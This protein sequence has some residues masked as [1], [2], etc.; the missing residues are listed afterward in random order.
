[1]PDRHR[2]L[3]EAVWSDRADTGADLLDIEGRVIAIEA[4]RW[5]QCDDGTDCPSDI[6][7]SDDT[8]LL[9][10]ITTVLLQ[11]PVESGGWNSQQSARWLRLRLTLDDE[12][13]VELMC[14]L[15]SGRAQSGSGF[16]STK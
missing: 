10:E 13:T 5:A 8:G 16:R 7:R 6:R 3:Y 1:M 11:A 12:S 15:K 2:Y 9:D 4:E 14:D